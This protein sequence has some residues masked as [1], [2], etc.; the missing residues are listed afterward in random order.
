MTRIV[1]FC[2]VLL[3]GC[4][5]SEPAT[6][7]NS[8]PT[9]VALP[10]P[11]KPNTLLE[12]KI[13]GVPQPERAMGIDLINPTDHALT[14]SDGSHFFFRFE[15]QDVIEVELWMQVI[16]TDNGQII[17]DAKSNFQMRDQLSI[18]VP[19]SGEV[20]ISPRSKIPCE[21]RLRILNGTVGR[22]RIYFHGF[23][24]SRAPE[25]PDS[26]MYRTYK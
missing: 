7:S 3:A 4:T 1:V 6:E 22:A 26:S 19:V 15:T 24:M 23:T 9:Q 11:T 5:S 18:A 20:E 14:L 10:E 25:P 21:V 16:R 8:R 12:T 2:L 17:A 13:D